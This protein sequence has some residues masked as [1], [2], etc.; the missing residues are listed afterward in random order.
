MYIASRNAK[1]LQVGYLV[2]NGTRTMCYSID[3][4]RDVCVL[5]PIV[6]F[7]DA[8]SQLIKTRVE[9]KLSAISPNRTYHLLQCTL[10]PLFSRTCYSLVLV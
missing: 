3:F 6:T 8:K 7:Y 4:Y 1:E 2:T 10:Y 5:A 9:G